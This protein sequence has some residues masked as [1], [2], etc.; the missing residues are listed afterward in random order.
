MSMVPTYDVRSTAQHQTQRST[1]LN[2]KQTKE[3]LAS[4]WMTHMCFV[5]LKQTKVTILTKKSP[6]KI[7]L[8]RSHLSQKKYSFIPNCRASY[9]TSS[10]AILRFSNLQAEVL[11]F[12]CFDLDPYVIHHYSRNGAPFSYRNRTPQLYDFFCYGSSNGY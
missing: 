6:M 4:P 10:I 2:R 9:I 11:S 3:Y 1:R 7:Q 5:C 8:R 12:L